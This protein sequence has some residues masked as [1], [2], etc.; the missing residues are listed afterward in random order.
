M[1]PHTVNYVVGIICIFI[2]LLFLFYA[3]FNQLKS[4]YLLSY[5]GSK[6]L[7]GFALLCY[8]YYQIFPAY[9]TVI[10]ANVL[11]IS[12][13]AIEV[14]NVLSYDKV[15]RRKLFYQI[16][17]F[18]LLLLFVLFLL[19]AE[20]SAI[21]AM[22][23]RGAAMCN[24]GFGGLV[25]LRRKPKTRFVRLVA[26]SYLLFALSWLVKIL[27]SSGNLKQ[28]Q[29]LSWD[30][31]FQIVLY[32]VA[33]LNLI[34][35][36]V[37]YLL[38]IKELD[39]QSIQLQSRQIETDNQR[40]QELNKKKDKFFSIIAHDLKNPLSALIQLGHILQKDYDK[41]PVDTRHE[42]IESMAESAT[43]TYSLLENL[44]LWSRSETGRIQVHPAQ[45]GLNHVVQDTLQLLQENIKQKQISVQLHLQDE[46]YAYC[47]LNMIQTV[48]R[49]LI[50]N[51]I[52]YVHKEGSLHIS[53]QQ[54]ERTNEIVLAVE[55][56]GVG[57]DPEIAAHIFD[58]DNDYSTKGTNNEIGTGLGLK[59]CK[60]FVQMNQGSI[61]VKS[62]V[63]QGSTFFVSLP[64]NEAG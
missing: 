34:I 33:C 6:F 23:T 15:F 19:S 4:F 18:N 36:S 32:S 46:L 9:I 48:V 58:L 60:E 20:R 45:V 40:L 31:S 2:G 3:F 53:L 8:S 43:K 42:M 22:I 44:L 51:A 24:F 17:V 16:L 39:E 49:N 11:L 56:N 54:D 7:Q 10:V 52:K 62:E 47:D 27:I 13:Y 25:L 35:S 38:M 61:S 57:I 30:N 50:S 28:H 5:A 59:I 12:G 37:G 14:F 41:L 29:F 26:F 55:D 1:D 63:M 21:V 64:A